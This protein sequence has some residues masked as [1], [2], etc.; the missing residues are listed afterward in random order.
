MHQ[1]EGLLD[2]NWTW[3]PVYSFVLFICWGGPGRE[4]VSVII[5]DG[6]DRWTSIGAICFDFCLGLDTGN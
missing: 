5:V 1:L 6:V 3:K 4:L 2:D